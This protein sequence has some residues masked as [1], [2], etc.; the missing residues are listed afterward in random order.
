MIH[1]FNRRELAI[2]NDLQQVNSVR[3]LLAANR[4]EYLVKDFNQRMAGSV[5]AGRART[6]ALPLGR[7]QEQYIVYVHKDD[8]EYAMYL[9]RK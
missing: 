8:L 9:L 5:G 7:K 6:S 4:I 1:I 2:T 3:E